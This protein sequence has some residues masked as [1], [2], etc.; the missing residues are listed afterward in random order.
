MKKYGLSNSNYADF[1][2]CFRGSVE[3]Y[4]PEIGF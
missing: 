4:I 3:R 1:D 2:G